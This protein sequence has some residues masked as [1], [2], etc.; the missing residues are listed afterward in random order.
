MNNEGHR[1]HHP[2]SSNVEHHRDPEPDTDEDLDENVVEVKRRVK[3]I[4]NKITLEKFDTLLHAFIENVATLARFNALQALVKLVC[5]HALSAPKFSRVFAQLCAQACR[6][7]VLYSPN[8]DP[9]QC[10]GDGETRRHNEL[11]H[12]DNHFH[13][14]YG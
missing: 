14:C 12:C 8:M 7:E 5:Q 6:D 11:P 1:E 2:S 10:D 3:A 9:C 13:L 4:L